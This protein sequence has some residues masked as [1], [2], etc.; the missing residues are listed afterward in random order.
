MKKRTRF[1]LLMLAAGAATPALAQSVRIDP[2]GA[3]VAASMTTE[4]FVDQLTGYLD[5]DRGAGM[6]P[7]G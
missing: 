7:N 5:P 2:N 1:A 4:Q 3:P 6:D